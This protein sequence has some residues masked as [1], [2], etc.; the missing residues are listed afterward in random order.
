MIHDIV[1]FCTCA[2]TQINPI[3][4]QLIGYAGPHDHKQQ[5]GTPAKFL[6]SQENHETLTMHSSCQSSIIKRIATYRSH[7]CFK[8]D[9]FFKPW[10]LYYDLGLELYVLK[11]YICVCAYMCFNFYIWFLYI[12]ALLQPSYAKLP[13]TSNPKTVGGMC[14]AMLGMRGLTSQCGTNYK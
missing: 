3:W 2:D 12:L 4:P 11:M 5:S 13:A 1:Y 14:Y 8:L 9:L 10:K 7:H 6:W